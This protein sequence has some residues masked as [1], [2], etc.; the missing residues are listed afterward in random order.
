MK[1]LKFI[2]F[3]LISIFLTSFKDSYASSVWSGRDA[4]TNIVIEIPSGN[5]V[6]SGN[7]IEFYD[8]K[9]QNYH[10]ARVV[11]VQSSFGGS[12][13]VVEDLD[14]NNIIRTFLMEYQ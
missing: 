10:T 11:S 8:D 3:I 12:E 13:L 9:D 2:L 4:L 14:N 5:T 7:V 1:H 6:R